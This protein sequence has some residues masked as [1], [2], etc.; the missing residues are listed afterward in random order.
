MKAALLPI[1]LLLFVSFPAAAL[2]APITE[3]SNGKLTVTGDAAAETL[4]VIQDGLYVAVKGPAGMNDPDGDPDDGTCNVLLSPHRVSCLDS[5]VANVVVNGGAGADSITDERGGSS[6]DTETLNGG[7]GDDTLIRNRHGTAVIT[8]GGTGDDTLMA[9]T[10][11]SLGETDHGE[12]G[13]DTYVGSP[14]AV[15]RF[16]AD[17]G[18]DTYFAGSGETYRDT[19]SYGEVVAPVT[20]TLDG[21]PNDG[22]ASEHD[23]VMPDIELIFG[24]AAADRITAGAVPLEIYGGAGDDRLTGGAGDDSLAGEAGH[25]VLLG[26]GGDDQLADGDVTPDVEDPQ[27]PPAGNDRLDGGPGNDF[28]LTDRGAD[29]LHG[30]PGYDD[31]LFFRFIP[32]APTAPPPSLLAAFAISLDDRAND[33]RRGANEGDNV[34]SDV[35]QIDTFDGDDV[36]T[37]SPGPDALYSGDGNDR[38]DPGAGADSVEAG[39]GDDV[40]IALD[41]ATD[42]IDC[43]RGADRL[44]AD[45]PGAQPDRADV[46][47]GCESI[48][49]SPLGGT[50]S[51]APHVLL[52]GIRARMT[53]RAF[54]RGVKVRVGADEPVAIEVALR[55]GRRVVAGASLSRVVGTRAVRL[56]PAR[57][58]RGG[59]AVRARVRVV[60]FDAAGNRAVKTRSFLVSGRRR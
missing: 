30:G 60:A 9:G 45:L 37:G 18:A 14:T 6:F 38:I 35:E 20:V 27:L 2:A 47:F 23:N 58:L 25:D 42:R 50:D 43:G 41:G 3:L 34:H 29:D 8:Q 16:F 59:H 19:M 26:G 33:G 15:D 1:S 52:K 36:L 17:P 28:L 4:T 55:I 49:G 24:G 10:G 40:V 57:R 21:R 22:E 5:V 48:T 51:R 54:N 46:A 11:G 12:A 13:D 31:A 44:R 32:R 53:R 39:R 7:A 56:K